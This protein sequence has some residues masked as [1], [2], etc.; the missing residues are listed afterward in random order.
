[1]GDGIKYFFK[2]VRFDMTLVRKLKVT[3][4]NASKVGGVL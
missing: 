1:M 3:D 2:K 4:L